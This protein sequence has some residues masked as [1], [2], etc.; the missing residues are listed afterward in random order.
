MSTALP[1]VGFTLTEMS[2]RFEG[3]CFIP[4]QTLD[5]LPITAQNASARNLEENNRRMLEWIKRL[6]KP[7]L[8]NLAYVMKGGYCTGSVS[9]A[10]GASGDTK[11]DH[12][13]SRIPSMIVMS[14]DLDGIG[15]QILGAPQG[16]QG[17]SGG[18]ET[19]WTKTE[20]YVR[21]S[22]SG[23]YAFIIL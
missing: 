10:T 2:E 17:S 19:P 3:K 1:S 11:F 15:G 23:R 14:V 6:G 8:Y 13:F 5:T 12:G 16:G 7:E 4:T 9:A 22:L 20:F 21:G 18:N